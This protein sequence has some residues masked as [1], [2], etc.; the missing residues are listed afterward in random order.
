MPRNPSLIF[1]LLLILLLAGSPGAAEEQKP[2]GEDDTVHLLGVVSFYYPRLMYQKYQPLVDYLNEYT[3]QR[4]ELRIST[5][6]QQTVDELCSGRLTLAYLGP[7][8]YVRAHERCGAEPLVRL[9]TAGRDSYQSYILVREDSPYQELADLQGKR[10]AFGS[11]LSTSSHLMPRAML[12]QA[13]FELGEE[14]SC[15]Y[16]EHHES[17]ARAVVLGDVEAC[18]VRDLVGQ[19]FLGRGLRALAE[20]PSI[21]NFPFV[22]SPNAP[23]G[24]RDSLLHV[25]VEL[26]RQTPVIAEKIGTWD[27]EL[28]GGFVPTTDDEYDGVR[29]L[30][31]EVFGEGALTLPEEELRC[32]GSE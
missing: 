28:A 14:L 8:T 22:L 15:L 2:V 27:E 1:A 16:L 19:R 9:H 12:V 10:I 32:S 21:P 17:A 3:E 29:K 20:S 30:A 31:T 25:L 18:G 4:W 26:P 23:A 5:T 7:L 24:S 6:Y 11:A 13:G